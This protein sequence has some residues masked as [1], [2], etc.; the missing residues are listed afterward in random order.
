M[1]KNYAFK[2]FQITA[3]ESEMLVANYIFHF[4]ALKI[5]TK[6]NLLCKKKNLSGLTATPVVAVG[7]GGEVKE[8]VGWAREIQQKMNLG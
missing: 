1:I 2:L 7:G 4:Q 5:L 8:K 3:K 6:S